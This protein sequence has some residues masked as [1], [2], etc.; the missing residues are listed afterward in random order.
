MKQNI[1][2]QEGIGLCP[3]KCQLDQIQN[4]QFEAIIDFS[5]GR[6]NIG[7]NVQD[8]ETITIKQNVCRF[9]GWIC[10][11]KCQLDLIG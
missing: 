6:P 11:E 7:K 9:Q 10:P 8:S 1:P 3:E 5:M 2:F 4:R